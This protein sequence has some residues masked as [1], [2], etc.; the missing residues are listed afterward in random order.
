[1]KLKF[2]LRGIGIGIFTAGLVAFLVTLG[3]GKVSDEQVIQRA[4]ELGYEKEEEILARLNDSEIVKLTEDTPINSTKTSET[5]SDK[6]VVEEILPS[7]VKTS[8]ENTSEQASSEKTSEEADSAKKAEEDAAKKAEEE[9]AKKA[10]EEAAKKAEEEAKKKAEEEEKKK[11]E[12]E[13]KKKAEEEAKKKAEEEEKKKAEEEA[14]KKAEEEAAKKEAEELAKKQASGET[15]TITVKSGQFSETVAKMC[16]EAGLVSDAAK[17]DKYL[18]DN[19]Y[20][21]RISV[22]DHVIAKGASDEEI[23]KALCK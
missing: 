20:S 13:E 7:G 2:L 19:G 14:K 11:A 8:E 4:K 1:M 23:A 10:E 9:A 3:G 18:C 21:G 15:V 5:N 22:G 16:K 6:A 17:F 12:E